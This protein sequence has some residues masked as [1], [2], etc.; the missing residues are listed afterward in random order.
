M[1]EAG[2][3]GPL[4]SFLMAA[5]G[6]IIK[7]LLIEEELRE[8]YLRYAMSVIVSRALPDARDGLKPSQRRILVAMNDLNLGPR[9][10]FRKCSKICGD[11]VGNYHPHGT[12]SVYSTLVRMGQ[13]W[14]MRYTLID[15]QG[16]FGSIDPDP[17]AQMRY[18][19][20]RMTAF[21]EMM[22]ADLTE[23]TV[24]FVPN[25]EDRRQEPVVLP[26]TFPNLLVNGSQ[27]IAVGMATSLPPH[28]LGE[29]ID[30]VVHLIDHP[31]SSAADLS[32]YV[33]GPDFPTGGL[34][35][36]SARSL[37][38]TYRTGRGQIVV[39]SRTKVENDPR[40][41]G[42]QSI[43]IS[44]IPYQV[45]KQRIIEI[46]AECIRSGKIPGALN[47][48]DHSDRTDPVRIAIPLRRGEDP[49]IVLN[50]LFKFTPLQTTFN[51]HMLALVRGRPRTLSLKEL[52]EVFREH[53]VDVIRRRTRFRLRRA[54]ARLHILQGLRIAL[55]NIEQVIK[56]IRASADAPAARARLMRE[57]S[58]ELT[59]KQAQAVLDMRLARLT[60]LEH[61]KLTTDINETETH[62]REYRAIL[63]D[64][65]QVLD[66]IK[67]DLLEMK[68]KYADARR[69][70]I[71]GAVDDVTDEDLIADDE[72][73]VSI[74]HA[75]Y[76]KRQPLDTYRAQRRGGKGVLGMTTKEEDWTEHLFIA[77]MHDTLLI[78]TDRGRLHWL[79]VYEVPQ[80]SRTAKGRAT[81]NLLNIQKG[82]K[83]AS[84][85]PVRTFDPD[86]YLF[87]ATRKGTVKKTSLELFGNVRPAGIF[88]IKLDNDDRLIGVELT[89]GD[90]QVLL[91]TKDGQAV[92]FDETDV[93]PMGRVAAG[94]KGAGLQ[95][96]DEVVSLVKLAPGSQILTICENGYGKRT[97]IEEYRKVRRGAKGVI[98]INTSERNGK[99]VACMAVRPGDGVMVMT[100]GGLVVRMNVDE[101]STMGRAAQGV[102]IVSFRGD[103]D[104]VVAVARIVHEHENGTNE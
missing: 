68:A 53:R 10:A 97:E 15:P 45:G 35:C 25:Y 66:I 93:R 73:A 24:D 104:R 13:E 83:I 62:V 17:P 54:E 100:V 9:S 84:M 30:G 36:N 14:N 47:V 64:V 75:G 94:V 18:P 99:V 86:R 22:M 92:L 96:G 76:I 80:L 52:L 7:D 20:A 58:E 31:D 74:S 38:N 57:L 101:I 69:T 51:V 27:G 78:L 59:E 46:T 44:E 8:S 63:A 3:M 34:I 11:T 82:E 70:E 6:G 2:T 26:A 90:S 5:T 32:H 95:P 40:H 72:M 98:N 79:K 33:H 39:R 29:I 23:D 103:E 49:K 1:K 37:R 85:V 21:A 65:R 43:I 55:S 41:K 89:D 48:V 4:G 56:I 87:M 102:R 91:A 61:S 71:I 16:N 12:E 19:E 88:A 50:Q 77:S 67:K 42:R 28:N 81:V 60:A